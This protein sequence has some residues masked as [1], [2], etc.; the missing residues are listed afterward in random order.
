[1]IHGIWF[2]FEDVLAPDRQLEVSLGVTEGIPFASDATG[3]GIT[4]VSFIQQED[5]DLFLDAFVRIDGIL[6]FQSI[7]H[8]ASSRA[9]WLPYGIQEQILVCSL[10]L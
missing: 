5:I 7:C 2:L 1:M 6:E 8:T 4:F 10:L 3:Q 9:G